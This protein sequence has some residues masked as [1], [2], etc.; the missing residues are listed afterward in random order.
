MG[1]LTH[2]LLLGCEIPEDIEMETDEGDGLLETYEDLVGYNVICWPEYT[3]LVGAVIAAGAS[4]GAEYGGCDLD[5]QV[6]ID[7]LDATEP[8]ATALGVAAARWQ[9]FAAWCAEQGV[10]LPAPRVWLVRLEV[11]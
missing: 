6:P 9:A 4:G 2:A 7:A 11:A 5:D 10:V 3:S 8:Y 1:Q